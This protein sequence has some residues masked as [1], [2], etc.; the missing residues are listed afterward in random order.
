M[1]IRTRKLFRWRQLC[2]GVI[3]NLHKNARTIHITKCELKSMKNL[4]FQVRMCGR[5]RSIKMSFKFIFIILIVFCCV[6][7]IQHVHMYIRVPLKL[8]AFIFYFLINES[9]WNRE[10]NWEGF[11][12]LFMNFYFLHGL[13]YDNDGVAL[14]T[15]MLLYGLGL[16]GRNRSEVGN[17][18][19]FLTS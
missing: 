16:W 19:T 4:T 8:H 2:G 17:H 1:W 14:W 10:E 11:E 12:G 7:L 3:S 18:I 5:I 13:N 15:A 9:S 6:A